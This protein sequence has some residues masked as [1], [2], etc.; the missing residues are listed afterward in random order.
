VRAVDL[1]LIVCERAA[2]ERVKIYLFGSRVDVVEALRNVLVR[3]FEG[4]EIVGSEPGVYR[5]LTADED[6]GLVER[7]NGGGAGLL[8]VGL[9]C[10]YQEA[11]AYRQ[12]MQIDAVQ[13]CIGGVFDIISGR[14]RNAPRWMQRAGLEWLF[15]LLQEPRRLLRRYAVTNVRFLAL[16]LRAIVRGRIRPRAIAS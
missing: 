3:R 16:V 6:A 12:G 1:T 7:I 4:I 10:P 14:K 2:R 9:G 11:F 13:M 5:P 15:R 8:L